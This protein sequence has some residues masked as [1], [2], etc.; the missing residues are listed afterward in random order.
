MRRR[1]GGIVCAAILTFGP[2]NGALGQ[3]ANGDRPLVEI[4][5][6]LSDSLTPGQS[7]PIEI[8]V[9][10]RGKRVEN[11][12]AAARLPDG[13]QVLDAEPNSE[14]EPGSLRWTLGAMEAGAERVLHLRVAT[15]AEARPASQFASSVNVTYQASVQHTARAIVH[16]PALAMRISAPD[17]AQA[18]EVTTIGIT[19]ENKGSAAADGVVLQTVLPAGLS[20]PGGSDLETDV[21]TVQPG[22]SKRITLAVTPTNAGVFRHRVRLMCNGQLA[23]DQESRVVAQ[24][25]KITVTANGPRLLYPEWTGSFEV[26]LRNDDSRPVEQVSVVVSLPS[27]LAVVRSSDNGVYDSRD[28]NLRWHIS[29]L[30][31]GETRTLVWTGIARKVGDQECQIVAT[32]GVRARK[33]ATWRTAVLPAAETSAERPVA[34]TLPSSNLGAVSVPSRPSAVEVKWRPAASDSAVP[35]AASD[36]R[37]P[38]PPA[39]ITVGWNERVAK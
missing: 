1:I 33:T 26:A 28:R 16:Q 21:G 6:K 2:A 24:D 3:P 36:A 5:Q 4:E 30:K 14:R 34:P 15:M 8:R 31:P 22:E 18:G 27:G 39:L 23:V 9:R 35:G 10:N 11:V 13:W 37:E 38:R 29:V 7:V 32:T 17:T 25:L 12:I 20:H 19:I